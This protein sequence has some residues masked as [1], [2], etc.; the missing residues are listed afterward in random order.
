MPF[1]FKLAKR[2]ARLRSRPFLVAVAV[3]VG[4]CAKEVAS[5][6]APTDGTPPVT[7]QLPSADAAPGASIAVVLR[8]TEPLAAIQETVAFDPQRLR[9]EHPGN[10]PDQIGRAH[11]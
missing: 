1:L 2:V 8:A 7:I 10:G 3:V 4:A 11:V 5:L 6:S 9:Y